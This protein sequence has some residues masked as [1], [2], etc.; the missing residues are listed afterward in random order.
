MPTTQP[1]L[2]R[3]TTPLAAVWIDRDGQEKERQT[4]DAGTHVTNACRLYHLHPTTGV[5]TDRAGFEAWVFRYR[6]DAADFEA[7][8][9][10]VP[11]ACDGTGPRSYSPPTPP[12]CCGRPMIAVTGAKDTPIWWCAGCH[13]KITRHVP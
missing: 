11:A 3:L 4:L 13:T 1:T 8:T 12:A 9:G 5:Q 7:A 2:I 6:A 10:A